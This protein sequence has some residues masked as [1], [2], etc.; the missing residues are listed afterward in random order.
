MKI[1]LNLLF[2]SWALA[3][4]KISMV[5]HTDS[6]YWD[7]CLEKTGELCDYC[8]LTDFEI[9]ARD[10]SICDPIYD[11][12]MK[13]FET[14]FFTLGGIIVGFPLIAY[15]IQILVLTRCCVRANPD[16]DGVS[17]FECMCQAVYFTFCCKRFK[18]E[19]EDEHPED[20][21]DGFITKKICCFKRRVPK[22]QSACVAGED[23]DENGED[24]FGEEGEPGDKE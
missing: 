21:T 9:C 23:L 10:I 24:P 18:D 2:S 17:C 8:C 3:V 6:N 4:T 22:P 14:A 13:L 16:T 1:I 11:R 12:N 15:I 5:N 19:A 7:L 20:E